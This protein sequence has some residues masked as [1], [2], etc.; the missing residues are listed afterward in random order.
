MTENRAD[1]DIIHMPG[2]LRLLIEASS[3][4]Q[5]C[6]PLLPLVVVVALITGLLLPFPLSLLFIFPSSLL[7]PISL[8]PSL[9]CQLPVTLHPALL[10][11]RQS[12]CL[13]SGWRTPGGRSPAPSTLFM[14][15]FPWSPSPTTSLLQ[16]AA[17]TMRLV[18]RRACRGLCI[19]P[20]C[21][22]FLPCSL[23][24]CVNNHSADALGQ[25]ANIL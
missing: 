11:P 10:T 18:G 17:P 22:R 12:T 24:T 8:C 16:I 20:R 3:R 6:L 21:G 9:H 25:G 4:R 15:F 13:L 7:L 14:R 1:E 19:S 2:W 23:P 5:S